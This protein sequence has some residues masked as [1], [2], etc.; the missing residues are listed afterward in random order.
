MFMFEILSGILHRWPQ[1]FLRWKNPE[2]GCWRILGWLVSIAL[3]RCFVLL[4]GHMDCI[5]VVPGSEKP[6]V[7]SDA[8]LV[9]TWQQ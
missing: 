3:I 2:R 8:D 5:E 9:E 7:P 1:Q 6:G 4:Q